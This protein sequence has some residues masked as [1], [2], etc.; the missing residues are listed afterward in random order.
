MGVLL[1]EDVANAFLRETGVAL[2]QRELLGRQMLIPADDRFG[3]FGIIV[4]R[5]RPD[6]PVVFETRSYPND[7]LLVVWGKKTN[8]KKLDTILRRICT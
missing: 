6:E 5:L 7:V 1:A 2:T 4:G 8:V 3:T